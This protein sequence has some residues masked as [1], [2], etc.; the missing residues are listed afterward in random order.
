MVNAKLYSD[1]EFGDITLRKNSRSRSI[2]IRVRGTSSRNGT[3]ISVTVPWSLRYQD[4]IDYLDK[5]RQWIR[6]ALDRQEKNPKMRLQ[7]ENRYTVSWT[8]QL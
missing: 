3:R 4:G 1:P 7:K 6:E 5:R 2:S 8:G